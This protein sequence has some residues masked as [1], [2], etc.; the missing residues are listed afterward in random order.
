MT[1]TDV[2]RLWSALQNGY[3]QTD[4]MWQGLLLALSFRA[5]RF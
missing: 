2:S 3:P 1:E 4:L 5:L